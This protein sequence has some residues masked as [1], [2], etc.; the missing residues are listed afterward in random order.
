[1]GIYIESVDCFQQDGHF[2]YINPA[3]PCKCSH[4]N[5]THLAGEVQSF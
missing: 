3:N 4:L 5:N 2:Y 1:M